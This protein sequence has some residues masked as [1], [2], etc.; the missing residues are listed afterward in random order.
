MPRVPFVSRETLIPFG[1]RSGPPTSRRRGFHHLFRPF[2]KLG[3]CTDEPVDDFSRRYLE[4][5]VGSFA[6]LA[7]LRQQSDI[8]IRPEMLGQL[9]ANAFVYLQREIA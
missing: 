6:M 9:H 1:G 8:D 3:G 5:I 2:H 7:Q 4:M